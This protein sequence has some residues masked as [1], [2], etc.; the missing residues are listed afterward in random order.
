MVSM[1]TSQPDPYHLM[2]SANL[3]KTDNTTIAALIVITHK[4][5]KE[6]KGS[7]MVTGGDITLAPAPQPRGSVPLPAASGILPPLP[8]PACTP[9]PGCG[10]RPLG[11]GGAPVP[12]HGGA[13]EQPG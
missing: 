7:E 6:M 10:R 9:A 12:G 2:R 4:G 11:V 8:T 1:Q 5:Q 13:H 3:C